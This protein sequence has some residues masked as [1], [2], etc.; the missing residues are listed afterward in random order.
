[1]SL[2][3]ACARPLAAVKVAVAVAALV[4]V[5]AGPSAPV[6]SAAS[7]CDVQV[8]GHCAGAGPLQFVSSKGTTCHLSI[9]AYSTPDPSNPTY[10]AKTSTNFG[11][12]LGCPNS[13]ETMQAWLSATD[14]TTRVRYPASPLALSCPSG[15]PWLT[16]CDGRISASV[17][18]PFIQPTV[19]DVT[20]SSL[21]IALRDP[22]DSWQLYPTAAQ[23]ADCTPSQQR[24]TCTVSEKRETAR[25]PVDSDGGG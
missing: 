25:N 3:L 24:I 23:G 6:A 11:G 14:L 18:T 5:C 17:T 7:S 4:G 21:E 15:D 8:V 9:Y 20:V 22:T 16:D 10:L 13:V 12:E 19:L 2:S 1:M